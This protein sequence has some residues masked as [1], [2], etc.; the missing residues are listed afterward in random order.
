MQTDK[1]LPG[2]L[3][4]IAIALPQY[5]LAAS[6][7][8]TTPEGKIRVDDCNY[9]SY[10]ECRRAAGNQGDC[11]ADDQGEKLPSSQVAPYCIVTWSTE[12]KY[13]DYETCVQTAENQK[14]FCYLNP[15]YKKPDK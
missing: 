10:D 5:T 7:C 4:C 15:D 2:L 1:I 6:F 3:L 12:C 14:G 13:F 9:G 8:T 11:I